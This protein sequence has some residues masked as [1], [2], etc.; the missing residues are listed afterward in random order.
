MKLQ[1]GGGIE[2][3]DRS[4]DRSGNG[5][6]LRLSEG[7]EEHLARFHDGADTHR[8]H[9]LRHVVDLAEEP[10][11]VLRS[12]LRERLDA[13]AR[14][15]R[16]S[17]L[18]EPDVPIGADADDLQVDPPHRADLFLVSLAEA[19]DI[20]RIA[21]GDVDVL[22]ADVDVAEEILPHERDVGLRV[23]FGQADVFVEVERPH[24][25]PVEVELD[26]L[27]VEKL[28]RAARG[29]AEDRVGFV[30]YEAGD[31]IRGNRRSSLFGGLD[32]DF[33]KF[34]L[35]VRA[36]FSGARPRPARS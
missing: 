28:G 4:L 10:G 22:P 24:A 16:G 14:G 29:Q 19:G 9:V 5:L 33:H 21:V 11:I 23:V 18:V 8:D 26:Q 7:E 3:G 35:R 20:G 27:P 31:Q 34:K 12:A 30:A 32:D 25:A 36:R 1:G 15:Q 2:R 13:R 17:R 6:R